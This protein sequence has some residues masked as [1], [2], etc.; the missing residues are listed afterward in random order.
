MRFEYVLGAKRYATKKAVIAHC[1][2]ILDA[3]TL[4]TVDDAAFLL[5]LLG[6]H[7]KAAQKIGCGVRRFFVHADG[8]GGRCFWLERLDGTC[9][10]WSFLSCLAP[11]TREQ[12]VR[13]ALRALV[14]ADV[15]AFRDDVFAASPVRA[16]AITGAPVTRDDA[17]VDH[18][19]PDTFLSLVERFLVRLGRGYA[20]ILIKPTSDGCTVTRLA[21]DEVARAWIEFHRTH[22]VLRVTSAHA[23]LS[24]GGGRP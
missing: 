24:Q 23:N 11:P 2:S 5:D 15:V 8:F 20:E 17:H 13:S 3:A 7:R 12:E 21:D 19:P 14:S 10:D 1:R 22:A 16:C 9:T 4:P 18:Q 6:H